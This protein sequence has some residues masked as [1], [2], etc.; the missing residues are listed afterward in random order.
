MFLVP[1]SVTLDAVRLWS[2]RTDPNG[3]AGNIG[4]IVV[5]KIV[6][7]AAILIAFGLAVLFAPLP[8]GI[9]DLLHVF[10]SCC[11]AGGVLIVVFLMSNAIDWLHSRM[12]GSRP[13]KALAKII[14]TSI[15]ELSSKVLLASIA[16]PRLRLSVNIGIALLYQ[17]LAIFGY[18]LMSQVFD[19]S[20]SISQML[21]VST[22]MQIVMLLPVS[23]AGI[24]L[25]D[26]SLVYLLGLFSVDRGVS[27]SASIS[28]YPVAVTFAVLGWL[29]ANSNVRLGHRSIGGQ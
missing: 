17:L 3:I 16:I 6:G 21:F 26:V 19:F 24:G 11:L 15:A 8:P 5:D 23:I 1:S 28:G 20:L 14:P 4:A 22:M 25:K 13:I 29:V 2:V 27:L 7:I 10:A 12:S 18:Y 9:S